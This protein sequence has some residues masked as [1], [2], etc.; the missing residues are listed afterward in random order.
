[1]VQVILILFQGMDTASNCWRIWRTTSCSTSTWPLTSRHFSPWSGF[2]EL[3][4]DHRFCKWDMFRN[5]G[6]VQYFSP[7]ISADLSKM[8]LSFN[9]TIPNLVRIELAILLSALHV[10][11]RKMSWWSWFWMGPFRPE[12]TLTIGFFLHRCGNRPHLLWFWLI[13]VFI[14]RTWTR[15]AKPLLELWRCQDSTAGAQELWFSD[16]QSSKLTSVSR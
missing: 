5:R 15:E 6:L 13:V 8:A 16:P 2:E 12:L 1:M 4:F 14:S 11:P 7:Y 10:I 9:T 3:Y